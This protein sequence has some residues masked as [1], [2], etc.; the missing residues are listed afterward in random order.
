MSAIK[1]LTGQRF[2]RLL[3]VSRAE[4]KN[5]RT[6]WN[7]LCDCGNTCIVR[8][9][10]LLSG[11]T[12]SCGCLFKEYAHTPKKYFDHENKCR[13]YRIWQAIKNRCYNHNIPQ[14][15]DYSGRGITVCEE[16]KDDYLAF[17]NWALNN[18]YNDTLSIDRIDV[19][20]NYCPENC[21]WTDVKTQCRNKTNNHLLTY[22]GETHT[23]VEWSEI[24]G[25][26]ENALFSR[27]Y[28]GWSVEKALSTPL[29]RHH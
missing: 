2:G 18:G 5:G 13:L 8:K 1:D 21:R 20:G 23:V 27:L 28:R 4:S 7:C 11:D 14:Y 12:Q 29:L 25:I 3:V 6:C 26:S 19:N 17:R 15:K 24:I 10:E 16:W 9:S 22:N